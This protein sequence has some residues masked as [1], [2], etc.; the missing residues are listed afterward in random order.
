LGKQGGFADL[1]PEPGQGRE[2]V[3]KSISGKPAD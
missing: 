2:T 1:T 3:L